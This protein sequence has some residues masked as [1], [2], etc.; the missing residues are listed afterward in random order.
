[1]EKKPV[2]TGHFAGCDDS[3]ALGTLCE[4]ALVEHTGSRFDFDWHHAWHVDDGLAGMKRPAHRKKSPEAR[5]FYSFGLVLIALG[6]YTLGWIIWPAPTDGVEF[7]IPAG[8][9]PGAPDSE[10]FASLADYHLEISWPRWVRRGQAGYLRLRLTDQD[11]LPPKGVEATQVVL[12]EPQLFPLQVD[13]PGAIQSNLGDDQT[14]TL[15]W[16]VSGDQRG[17]YPGKL[18]TAFAFFDEAE[19]ELITIPVAVVDLEIEVI[20]LWGLTSPILI[21]FGLVCLVLGAGLFVLGKSF[22]IGERY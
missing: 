11:L 4:F 7:N 19:T 16:A 9:L 5:K 17:I 20:A 14:L 6:L 3:A 12:V 2:G 8:P 21:W 1:M 13:P 15:N 18:I 22:K 10:G